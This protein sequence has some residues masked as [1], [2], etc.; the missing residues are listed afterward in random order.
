MI[1]AFKGAGLPTAAYQPLHA[2]F[3]SGLLPVVAGSRAIDA[4]HAYAHVATGGRSLLIQANSALADVQDI[5]GRVA[6]RRYVPHPAGLIDIVRAARKSDG[7]FLVMLDGINRGATES[8][9]LPLMRTAV[10]HSGAI[11]L[12]HPS[13][14]EPGDPYR[15]ERRIEWPRHLLLAATLVEGPTTLPVAPDVWN[16]SVLIQMDL[17][18]ARGLPSGS[19]GDP[20][21]LDPSGPLF[22]APPSAEHCEWIQEVVPS[23]RSV[24]ERYE[25]GLRTVSNEAT[26]IQQNVVKGVIV[27]FLAS[28][29][30]EA[31][32]AVE[33]KAAEKAFGKS[34]GPWISLARRRVS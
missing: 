6:Q 8:F 5:F 27:P 14:V 17:E 23:V 29:E 12:F 16:D 1:A 11:A 15:M 33:A 25:G 2:A 34:L 21:E 30:D 13:A 7:L 26:A 20:S 19:A 31:A 32:R 9:L 22:A 24:A 18:G 28:I 3:A 4:L 10:R